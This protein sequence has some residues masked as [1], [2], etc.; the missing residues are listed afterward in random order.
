MLLSYD[1][2]FYWA[3]VGYLGMKGSNNNSPITTS[4]S[5]SFTEYKNAFKSTLATAICQSANIITQDHV[6]YTVV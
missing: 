6:D 5:Q 1:I 2:Y 3:I 4:L